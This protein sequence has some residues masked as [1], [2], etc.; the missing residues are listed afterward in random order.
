[1][2]TMGQ[3]FLHTGLHLS[4]DTSGPKWDA[5]LTIANDSLELR[6]R[7]ND[8]TAGPLKA[9]LEWIAARMSL[10]LGFFDPYEK[11]LDSATNIQA[12]DRN[13]FGLREAAIAA[14]HKSNGDWS[15]KSFTMTFELDITFGLRQG[16]RVDHISL[17]L[18][19]PY[20][21]S[22][23][24]PVVTFTGQLWP[25]YTT[26]ML[27]VSNL[28]SKSP[29]VPPLLP[30]SLD[31]SQLFISL[32]DLLQSD[33]ASPS[34]ACPR[35]TPKDVTTATITLSTDHIALKCTLANADTDDG[36]S[37]G[38]SIVTHLRL[39][40]LTTYAKYQFASTS[41]SKSAKLDLSFGVTV[42]MSPRFS[43]P[44]L[45]SASLLAGI[46]YST[47]GNNSVRRLYRSISDVN[48]A[49]M[50]SLFPKGDNQ[51]VINTLENI[52]CIADRV[53]VRVEYKY[54]RAGSS[55]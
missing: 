10:P 19:F 37:D 6:M 54:F 28:D 44:P 48:I 25:L 7:W 35:S 16:T 45:G 26:K 55:F 36:D 50:Y 40:Q 17:I 34:D 51:A 20:F 29:L 38:K 39:D 43:D 9:F 42:I 23:S 15:F 47:S 46:G 24:E 11:M 2:V 13:G 3:A 1:M 12:N 33:L 4:D 49:T 22:T 5:Y 53:R 30:L 18:T 21:A 27:E 32:P 52:N 41:P 8:E 31:K 14:I